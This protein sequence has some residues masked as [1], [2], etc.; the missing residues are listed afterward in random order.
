[1]LA[2][3]ALY[4]LSHL[5]TPFPSK[6]LV[7]FC[8]PMWIKSFTTQFFEDAS[9]AL[10]KVELCYPKRFIEIFTS[11][12]LGCALVGKSALYKHTEFTWGHANVGLALSQ[13]CL[14]VLLMRHTDTQKEQAEISGAHNARNA[15]DHQKQEN[16]GMTFPWS[17]GRGH[18]SMNNGFISDFQKCERTHFSCFKQAS[19]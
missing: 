11:R 1:M 4:L 19:V 15:C 5:P 18:S 7:L 3:Q 9:I 6:F 16:Q 17:L 8:E 10:W 2:E 13:I 14:V 12:T